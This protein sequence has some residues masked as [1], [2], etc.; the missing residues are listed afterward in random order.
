MNVSHFIRT[1]AAFLC[2]AV[3]LAGFCL[4][5]QAQDKHIDVAVDQQG[6]VFKLVFLNSECPDRQGEKGCIQAAQGSSPNL[7][8]ELDSAGNG[9]W[10]F[11]R[12]QFSPD[13]VH[14]GEPSYPLQPCTM[15]DFGL[16]P[17]D[18]G[19]GDASTAR[20]LANGKRVQIKDHNRN[21]CTTHYRIYAAPRDGGAEID[22]DPVID[23]RGGGTN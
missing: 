1:K 22:S 13:G 10:V 4:H 14:W 7:S 20:V 5:A 2:L 8:W 3:L 11:T 23:N 21:V 17:G 16:A 12:L 18:A 15:D 9:E 19:S 6:G